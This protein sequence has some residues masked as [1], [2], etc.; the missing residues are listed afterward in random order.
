MAIRL[1]ILAVALL[2]A[3]FVGA[4]EPPAAKNQKGAEAG[5]MN[6]KTPIEVT[7]KPS[8]AGGKLRIEYAVVNRSSET[9]FIFDRMWD[10]NKDRLDVNWTYV[11][12]SGKKAVLK[13]A[14]EPMPAGLT[15]EEMP[16]PYGREIAP[17]GRATGAFRVALPLTQA[18]AY[19]FATQP[20]LDRTVSVEN[21]E[22][23]LGWCRKKEFGEY[24]AAVVPVK[25]GSEMLWPFSFHNIEEVQK[26]A[27]SAP[28]ELRLRAR[29]ASP[30]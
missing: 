28:V 25:E 19:D 11:E 22:L 20:K 17:G 13:R 21:L 6:E 3:S 14:L 10:L 30:R 27:K 12:I 16:E 29:A 15:M 1:L 7:F 9:I 2:R 23:Q 26:I 24:A 8:V 5:S 18:G 4:G